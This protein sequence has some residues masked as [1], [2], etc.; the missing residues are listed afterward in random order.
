LLQDR[1]LKLGCGVCDDE[2][3]SNLSKYSSF[4]FL[5]HFCRT[6][7]LTAHVHS[8]AHAMNN[9]VE[10]GLST[11]DGLNM[12]SCKYLIKNK[13]SQQEWEVKEGCEHDSGIKILMLNHV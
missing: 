8:D 2:D 7:S 10:A 13:S 4:V 11:K 1:D 5:N 6:L 3:L 9:V 12:N